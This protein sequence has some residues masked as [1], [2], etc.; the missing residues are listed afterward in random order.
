MKVGNFFYE[1][2]LGK[3]LKPFLPELTTS[4]VITILPDEI[5]TVEYKTVDS[6]GVLNIDWLS[7]LKKMDI[8]DV[9]NEVKGKKDDRTKYKNKKDKS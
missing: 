6:G 4:I 7:G 1:T 9:P 2:E 3:S 8:C 5:I